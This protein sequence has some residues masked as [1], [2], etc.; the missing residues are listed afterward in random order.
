MIKLLRGL[1]HHG[2]CRCAELRKLFGICPTNEGAVTLAWTSHKHII[3]RYKIP[4][5]PFCVGRVRE[6]RVH[7]DTDYMENNVSPPGLKL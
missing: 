4:G 5:K 6:N 7:L 3:N 1:T 2:G